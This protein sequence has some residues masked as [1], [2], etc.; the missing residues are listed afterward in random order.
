MPGT[1]TGMVA[2][3]SSAAPSSPA[4]AGSHGT[5]LD[6]PG[7][8]GS[9]SDG[10]GT[11]TRARALLRSALAG[12]PTSGVPWLELTGGP[13]AGLRF[14]VPGTLCLGRGEEA[15]LPL[16]DPHLSRRHLLL[17]RTGAGVWIAD[18]ASKNGTWLNGRPLRPG[19]TQ[20]STGNE[21]SMGSTRMRLVAVPAAATQRAALGPAPAPRGR[22]M[23]GGLA[24]A[25]LLGAAALAAA[26]W[27]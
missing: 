14:P 9:G 13:H 11:A 19:S 12:E 23:L 2:T 21:I 26:A 17:T 16:E 4:D 1:R 15:T 18:L 8:G 24:V 22:E 27:P 5:G 10:A 6:G 3:P 25:L 7:S 20:I